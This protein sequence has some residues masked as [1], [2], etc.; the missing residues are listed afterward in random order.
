[1][2]FASKIIKPPCCSFRFASE[3]SVS[4]SVTFPSARFTTPRFLI[5]G[6]LPAIRERPINRWHV[7]TKQTG[8]SS[9]VNYRGRTPPRPPPSPVFVQKSTFRECKTAIFSPNSSCFSTLVYL[10][11]FLQLPQTVAKHHDFQGKN[12]HFQGNDRHFL[13]T[14]HQFYIQ[15]HR[16]KSWPLKSQAL[17][18]SGFAT[19]ARVNSASARCSFPGTAPSK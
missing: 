9:G 14:N 4:P 8:F 1:M 10:L 15:T 2:N 19:S 12:R 7:Y 18:F 3:I 13:L 16:A 6:K 11:R 5:R 17:S